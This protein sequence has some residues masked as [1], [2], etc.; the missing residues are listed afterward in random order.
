MIQRIVDNLLSISLK[1]GWIKLPGGPTGKFQ[2]NTLITCT[3]IHSPDIKTA[4][5]TFPGFK[6]EALG[7][8]PKNK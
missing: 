6:L 4:V 1:T 8:L 2:V 5:L 7:K 3:K